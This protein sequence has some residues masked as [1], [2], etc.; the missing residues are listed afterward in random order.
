LLGLQK[1]FKKVADAAKEMGLTMS[2]FNL[3]FKIA[4]TYGLRPWMMMFVLTPI[5]RRKVLG[6]ASSDAKSMTLFRHMIQSI[7]EML[8][9]NGTLLTL[10]ATNYHYQGLA[11]RLCD[12]ADRIKQV[13]GRQKDQEATVQICSDLVAFEGVDVV[14]P[15]GNVLVEDLTFKLPRGGALLVT[16]HNGAGKSSIFRC[17]GGLWPV[18]KGMISKPPPEQVFYMPQ[19]PYNVVGTLSSQMSYP[20]DQPIDKVELHKL[21]STVGLSHL[22]D[23][24]QGVENWGETLSL[25]EQQRLAMA[26]LLYHKP[27]FAVLDEC[28][29]A[30]SASM[31]AF[32][33]EELQ[34]R[35]ITYITI[36][37]RPV[38]KAY[39]TTNLHLVGEGTRKYTLTDL[40]A[41]TRPREAVCT[42]LSVPGRT[43]ANHVLPE[44]KSVV[45]RVMRLIKIMIPGTNRRI[46]ILTGLVLLRVAFYE[47]I[48]RASAGLLGSVMRGD[49]KGFVAW[50]LG[51]MLL[52]YGSALV[53]E[54]VDYSARRLA[55]SWNERLT[56][57]F[58]KTWLSHRRFYRLAHFQGGIPDADQRVTSEMQELA[59][60]LSSMVGKVLT[61]TLDLLWFSGRI[62][63]LLGSHGVGI[64]AAYNIAVCLILRA[65]M[66]N[67]GKLLTKEKALESEYRFGHARLRQQA[68]SVAFL[69]GGPREKQLLDD[70]FGKLVDHAEVYRD[71]QAMYSSTVQLIS[72]D[73]KSYSR[74]MTVP[75]LLSSYL[76]TQAASSRS[77]QGVRVA[78]AAS[79]TDAAVG[80]VID[81]FAN[82]FTVADEVSKLVGAGVRA[83]EMLEAGDALDREE[84]KLGYAVMDVELD[85]GAVKFENASIITPVDVTLAHSLTLDLG[86]RESLIVTG[87]NSVGKTSLLRL[88]AGLW[89]V[90]A[91]KVRV[92]CRPGEDGVGTT[93]LVPQHAF[94]PGGTL[95]DLVTYP[96]HGLTDRD[97]DV[98]RAL[99]AVGLAALA[100]REGL[101]Q[102]R[103]WEDVLSLGEQQRVGLSR[104]FFHHPARGVLDEC[105]SAVSADGERGLYEALHKSGVPIITMSQR[106]ALPEFHTRELRLGVSNDK[107][108][109]VH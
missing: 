51:H 4:Y 74:G 32:F 56:A 3:T 57:H 53:D 49:V 67:H 69:Q 23:R 15:S 98:L 79:Y 14:T 55:V 59:Q 61:P 10:H 38:L 70:T 11:K 94:C 20:F 65:A 36:C 7:I 19:K 93:F 86:A 95:R 13:E 100:E 96:K 63:S 43:H 73:T 103:Q 77:G 58:Q 91:G 54:G 101:E 45:E 50:N 80:R 2:K 6:T 41:I 24:D 37:H 5:L 27:V 16:G 39:H 31:E 104:L 109:E 12:I 29:S 30:V 87:P 42:E 75:V 82:F 81:A 71:R 89:P 83:A 108:H 66:P 33:Y 35:E 28:T 40:P 22:K 76:Q 105:T 9:G 97:D 25:G 60:Q 26:R 34:R 90:H 52:D 68:E 102:S 62:Y 107:C 8:V 99:E 84:E 88:M 78:R 92:G 64:L 1:N 72:K 106:L 47:S 18:S 48:G 85:K 17:L 44:K 46:A 21:L